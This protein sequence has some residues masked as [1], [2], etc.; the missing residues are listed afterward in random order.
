MMNMNAN[1]NR[2]IYGGVIYLNICNLLNYM[3]QVCSINIFAGLMLLSATNECVTQTHYADSTY[4]HNG[5]L[6][7]ISNK[8]HKKL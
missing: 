6:L 4:K 3:H 8:I 7:K 5:T 1:R 2:P